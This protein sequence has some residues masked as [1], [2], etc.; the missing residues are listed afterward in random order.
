MF[1]LKRKWVSERSVWFG[2]IL[3]VFVQSPKQKCKKGCSLSQENTSTKE[4]E[5]EN[6]LFRKKDKKNCLC[7]KKRKWV[8]ERFQNLYIWTHSLSLYR[9][10]YRNVRQINV[11]CLKKRLQQKDIKR[12]RQQEFSLFLEKSAACLSQNLPLVNCGSCSEL[13]SLEQ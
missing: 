4:E 3:C 2:H 6:V 1:E 12:K 10:Q 13:A 8:S 11:L 7:F 9:A 5:K